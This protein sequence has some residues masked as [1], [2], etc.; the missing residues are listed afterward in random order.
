MRGALPREARLHGADESL[1][2]LLSDVLG[3]MGIRLAPDVGG[4]R[5]DVVLALV[6]RED[7]VPRVLRAVEE[8]SGP[9]PVLVL[10]PFEDERLRCLAMR[11]G[12]Q[13]CY[14]LGTPL[15]SLKRLL[16]DM[17]QSEAPGHWGEPG[18]HDEG[19]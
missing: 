2:S 14:A 13:G 1:R 17:S 6:E 12:A 3:D 5:P 11:L 7:S 19:A 16:R 18:R 10:L 15:E 9:A 8:S 4:E